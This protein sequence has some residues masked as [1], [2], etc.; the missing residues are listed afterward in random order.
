MF[1]VCADPH[2]T[3]FFKSRGHGRTKSSIN[4]SIWMP[5]R[6]KQCLG[7]PD[8]SLCIKQTYSGMGTEQ[9]YQKTQAGFAYFPLRM[10]WLCIVAEWERMEDVVQSMTK[11]IQLSATTLKR[12]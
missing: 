1:Q 6:V 9:S 12:H 3:L 4:P 7:C 11:L 8:F 2:F 5:T 10:P